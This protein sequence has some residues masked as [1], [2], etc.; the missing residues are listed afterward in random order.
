MYS[1]SPRFSQS[2]GVVQ[3]GLHW[4][5][6][7]ITEGLIPPDR[8]EAPSNGLRTFV[9]NEISNRGLRLVLLRFLRPKIY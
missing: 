3:L 1:K 6:L 9:P 5:C 4:R 8:R 7:Y 2:P